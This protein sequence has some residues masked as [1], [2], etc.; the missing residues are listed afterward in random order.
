GAT[1]GKHRK[2]GF[3]SFTINA[4]SLMKL[5]LK[6]TRK[7]N[8]CPRFTFELVG[9]R[10]LDLGPF[11]QFLHGDVLLL[12]GMQNGMVME[13]KIKEEYNRNEMENEYGMKVV[14]RPLE[15]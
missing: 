9:L 6:E 2:I 3:G 10:H 8:S 11:A 14:V 1:D 12:D 13:I 7:L 4:N 15:K 5:L